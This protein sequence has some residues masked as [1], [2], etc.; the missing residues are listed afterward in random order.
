MDGESL[1]HEG[2]PCRKGG[3]SGGR[4]DWDEEWESM[5]RREEDG[6]GDD[7]GGEEE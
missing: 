3:M 7:D 5:R 1:P 6:D 4:R 2:R